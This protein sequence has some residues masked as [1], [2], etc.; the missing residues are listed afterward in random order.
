M[1]HERPQKGNPHRLTVRQHVFPARSIQRFVGQDG[2]VY[3]ADLKRGLGRLAKP[4][5]DIFCARRAWHESIETGLS[6]RIEDAFQ[7]AVDDILAHGITAVTTEQAI[8]ISDFY[9]LWHIRSRYR[10]LPSEMIDLVGITGGGGLSKDQEER[11]EKKGYTF[12]REGGRMPARH[13]NGIQI[14]MRLMKASRQLQA[15]AEWGVAQ[16]LDG[17]FI[18]PDVPT[19]TL[20]PIAPDLIIVSPARCGLIT[21]ENVARINQ[22]AAISSLEYLFARRLSDCPF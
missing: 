10:A 16:S 14:Q 17:H 18:A 20:I 13:I 12:S 21:R 9:A 19:T 5:D 15:Q 11:L 4:G 8:A 6:T 22:A 1:A 3:L 2:A 7:S